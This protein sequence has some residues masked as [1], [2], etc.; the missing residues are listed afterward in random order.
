[1]TVIIYFKEYFVNQGCIFYI[2]PPP[3]AGGHKNGKKSRCGTRM[4]SEAVGRGVFKT[5]SCGK[6]MYDLGRRLRSFKAQM[7]HK[8]GSYK[9]K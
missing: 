8:C 9:A 7:W 1:M 5:S 6:K 2:I 4:R 3:G